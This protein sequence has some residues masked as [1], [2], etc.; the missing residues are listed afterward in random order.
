M[1][2]SHVWKTSLRSVC[3]KSEMSVWVRC[4]LCALPYCCDLWVP[5]LPGLEILRAASWSK[6]APTASL[7][8]LSLGHLLLAGMS[9]IQ[10][11]WTPCLGRASAQPVQVKSRSLKSIFRSTMRTLNTLLRCLSASWGKG[12]EMMVV[13][14]PLQTFIL[15]QYQPWET[16]P[17][18][19]DAQFLLMV[20]PQ[21]KQAFS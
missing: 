13:V 19:D 4:E 7:W 17:L 18:E 3:L 6:T 20:C 8:P 9:C 15:L 16:F 2:L 11:W 1:K 12:A 14:H 21:V 5:Q 10:Q